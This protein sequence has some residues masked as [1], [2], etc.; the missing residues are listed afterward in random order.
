MQALRAGGFGACSR[1]LQLLQ[2]ALLLR[3]AA[4]DQPAYRCACICPEPGSLLTYGDQLYYDGWSA[5]PERSLY[6]RQANQQSSVDEQVL[7]YLQMNVSRPADCGCQ[8][9]MLPELRR[10]TEPTVRLLRNGQFCELCQCKL[11]A[12]MLPVSDLRVRPMVTGEADARSKVT[13]S[14]AAGALTG[15]QRTRARRAATARPERL[16]EHGVIPYEIEANFS[17]R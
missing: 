10:R 8:R 5:P 7:L 15:G 4:A 2:L 6:T 12:K 11:E 16:W 3:L 1:L 14:S 9:L 17:G 13:G